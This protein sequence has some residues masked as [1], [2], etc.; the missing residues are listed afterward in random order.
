MKLVPLD[1][2]GLAIYKSRFAK[3]AENTPRQF[4]KMTAGEMI[5]HV[6]LLVEVSLE[7]R[8]LPDFSN[9][10]SRTALFRWVLIEILPWPK[11]KVKAPVD[12]LDPTLK[13]FDEEHR[14]LD[15]ALERF[16]AAVHAQPLRITRSPMVGT[17]TLRM[18][19]R[20]HGRH[21]EHH[22]Q[23]FGA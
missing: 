6:R 3:I 18:W 22:L 20:I 23:Q 9:W 8:E 2:A 14:L 7:E 15:G 1:P 11:G 12:L 17:I 4:G 10:L 13:S 16:A 19:S 5:N 21:L